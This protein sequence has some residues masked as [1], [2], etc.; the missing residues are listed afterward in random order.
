MPRLHPLAVVIAIAVFAG[1]LP[2]DAAI[3]QQAASDA[4]VFRPFLD[5]DARSPPGFRRPD[6][7]PPDTATRFV[8]SSGRASADNQ[9]VRFDTPTYGNPPAFGAGAS[10]YDSTN[11]RRKKA[12][13]SRT[14][15]ATRTASTAAAIAP[16]VTA[17]P[18]AA[19]NTATVPR[20]A[21]QRQLRTTQQNDPAASGASVPEPIVPLRRR[22]PAVEQD[23][24]EQLGVRTGGFLVRPA[25]ELIGG[26]DSNPA[27]VPNSG[28]S[29]LMIVAPEL[30]VHSDWNRHALNADI[31]GT[32]TDYAE[33][34]VPS[35]NRPYA[36][37]RIN[38]RID[39]I[40]QSHADIEGRLLVSTDNPGSPNIQAGLAKLPIFT[41]VGG[42]VGYTQNL[43]RLD[44]TLKGGIDRTDYQ[45]STLTDGSKSS[46]DDRN[47][48]QY[49]GLLRGS[50]EVTP[51]VKPFVEAGIDTRI[52]DL[53]ID[54]TGSDR[55]SNGFSAR[56]GTTFE[57]T[58]LLTGEISAGYMNRHYRD[59]S[60]PDLG[61]AIFDASLLWTASALTKVL[62]TARSS[63]DET[64]LAGV[65]GTFRRDFAVQVDHAF[66]RW[67][68]GTF[69]AGIG[70]DNYIGSTRDDHRYFVSSALVY[71]LTRDLQIKGELRRDWLHSTAPGVDYT[72]DSVLV[73]LRLQR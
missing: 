11:T 69:K 18:I 8:Q 1:T 19:A 46:N 9:P 4:N 41:T 37:G 65:S 45:E 16:P 20:E 42:S 21:P 52:H 7:R 71:K 67:L 73:G 53:P 17:A 66:R 5:G 59:P 32:Y 27:H 38:G 31:R 57:L 60:L 40:G 43:N 23:P 2:P 12:R 55:D 10:G 22:L 26:Y 50:Y 33:H 6:R 3:A 47:Y 62:L 29:A 15:A 48:D 30:Q 63:A 24:F 58:R 34:F 56:V 36:D 35:L 49:S 44:V 51:G 13:A 68:V 28:G 14:R 54:R 64:I 61:G 70:L 25:L 39:V 72:A